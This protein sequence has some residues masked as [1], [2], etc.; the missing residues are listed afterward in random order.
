MGQESK[1]E[2][3]RER[4]TPKIGPT[5]SRFELDWIRLS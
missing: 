4:N 2:R 1:Q 3:E 5:Q